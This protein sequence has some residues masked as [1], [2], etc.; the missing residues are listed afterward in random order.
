MVKVDKT[1]TF[2]GHGN[3]SV[4]L[5][6]LFQGKDQLI[7]YHFMFKPEDDEGCRGCSHVGE[8]IPNVDHLRLKN[9][10]LVCVSRAPIEKLEAF[11][12]ARVLGARAVLQG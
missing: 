4:T 3:E 10:N 9:T 11:T 2:K 1:Y 8:N 12:I 5:G 7:V 6:D